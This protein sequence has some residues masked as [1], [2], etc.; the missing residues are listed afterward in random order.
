MNN[1]RQKRVYSR[2]EVSVSKTYKQNT[3]SKRVKQAPITI[4]R[5]TAINE[6]VS[7][8]RDRQTASAVPCTADRASPRNFA[9]RKTAAKFKFKNSKKNL[10]NHT[11]T[12]GRSKI[13]NGEV[14]TSL[15]ISLVLI[16][17]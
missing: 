16:V 7:A 12:K 9:A 3:E 10:S 5:V 2:T 4:L 15:P 6:G 17:K 1:H 14:I 13:V 8:S 11:C